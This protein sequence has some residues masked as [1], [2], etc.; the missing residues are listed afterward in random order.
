MKVGAPLCVLSTLVGFATLPEDL[1]I[2][3][4]AIKDIAGWF[5]SRHSYDTPVLRRSA[6]N[7]RLVRLVPIRNTEILA[8]IS[9]VD[10]NFGC[11][12]HGGI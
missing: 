11:G 5:W 12:V 9:I 7:L 3:H 4:R 2:W 6:R 10:E 1:G 8:E